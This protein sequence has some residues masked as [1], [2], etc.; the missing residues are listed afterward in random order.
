MAMTFSRLRLKQHFFTFLECIGSLNLYLELRLLLLNA[1][2]N[3]LSHPAGNGITAAV[4]RSQCFKFIFFQLLPFYV[5]G[6]QHAHQ[7]LEGYDIIDV[8]LN[9]ILKPLAFLGDTWPD[10]YYLGLWFY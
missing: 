9:L 2:D 8:F 7:L 5:A 1:V 4:S 6:A 3:S 10:K